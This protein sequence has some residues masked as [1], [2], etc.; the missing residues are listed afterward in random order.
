[1]FAPEYFCLDYR[2]AGLT[3]E[4]GF[5]RN[6]GMVTIDNDAAVDLDQEAREA[7][8]WRY[9]DLG[10]GLAPTPAQHRGCA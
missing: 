8:V 5:A 7:A 3:P 10:W 9:L 1:M 4:N 2:A 6:A